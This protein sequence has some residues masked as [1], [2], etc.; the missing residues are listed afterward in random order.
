MLQNFESVWIMTYEIIEFFL[1]TVNWS[2]KHIHLSHFVWIYSTLLG[3]RL[4]QMPLMHS[5]KRCQCKHHFNPQSPSNSC[6]QIFSAIFFLVLLIFDHSCQP[7]FYYF[8]SISLDIIGIH[9]FENHFPIVCSKWFPKT[10]RKSK[11]ISGDGFN[12][13]KT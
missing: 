4:N 9:I 3:A 2:T 8:T 7:L 5:I 11:T 10:F 6:I 12:G 1:P 13:I